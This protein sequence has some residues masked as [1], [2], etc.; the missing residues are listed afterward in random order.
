[1]TKKY[2]GSFFV[3]DERRNTTAIVTALLDAY[4]TVCNLNP[5]Y[6]PT[7]ERKQINSDYDQGSII[8]CIKGTQLALVHE[9]AREP[10]TTVVGSVIENPRLVEVFA[11]KSLDAKRIMTFFEK[12]ML[13]RGIEFGMTPDALMQIEI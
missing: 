1:M 11:E 7:E 13:Q 6:I 12:A 8:D 3:S 5:Q 9:P 10:R 2:I 4:R